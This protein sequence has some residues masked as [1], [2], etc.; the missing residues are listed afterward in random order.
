M[1]CIRR[2]ALV[3]VIGAVL[4]AGVSP[5]RLLKAQAVASQGL[6]RASR[7]QL[8]ERVAELERQLAAGGRS[9]NRSAAMTE[10]AAIKQ[11]LAEGDFRVGNQFVLNI[12]TSTSTPSDTVSVRDSLVVSFPAVALPGIDPVTIPEMSVRGLLR[13]E[14]DERLTTHVARYL[15]GVQVRANVLTRI[16]ISGQVGRTGFYAASPDRPIGD[17]LMLAGGP[18]AE[19]KLDEIEITRSGR[20]ILAGKDSKKAFAEGRTLDQLDVQD[21]DVVTVPKKKKINWTQLIQVFAL[22]TTLIF[23]V[24]QFVQYYYN[25]KE[26]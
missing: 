16:T 8:A 15:R 19:A 12:V 20:K 26:D 7:A 21:G 4:L 14:L 10:A 24:L 18:T 6:Q 2:F 23:A 11:R 9:L 1:S 22:V 17:V 13:S 3:S 25:Q 5:I